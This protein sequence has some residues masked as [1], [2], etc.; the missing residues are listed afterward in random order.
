MVTPGIF[1]LFSPPGSRIFAVAGNGYGTMREADNTVSLARHVAQSPSFEAIYRE[2][3]D[4]VEDAAA[5]L[6]GNGRT[7]SRA[8]GPETATL[9]ASE[10]MRLTTR[11]MQLA[12]W[13]LLQRAANSGEMTPE[14][15]LE[16][17]AK[18]R[19]EGFSAQ[20]GAVAWS[21]LPEAFRQLVEHSLVL[22]KRIA[23]L[24]QEVY[25][26]GTQ[27]PTRDNPVSIQIGALER[28]FSS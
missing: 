25:G 19:L 11:L 22:Q 16:E 13:L 23:Y 7:A 28:A 4:L 21:D 24:D 3:M 8:M 20:M 1:P 14:Q 17:K 5:Y 2:G 9:Y 26:E 12:S 15:V 18:V 10:S 6:D 27:V